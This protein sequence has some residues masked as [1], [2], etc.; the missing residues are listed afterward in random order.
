MATPTQRAE[1]LFSSAKNKIQNTTAEAYGEGRIAG[2][3]REGLADMVDGLSHLAAGV[4]ATYMLLEEV[5]K[6]VDQLRQQGRP[7]R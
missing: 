5:Q 7:V 3:L 2:E 6:S 4:R 1:Q